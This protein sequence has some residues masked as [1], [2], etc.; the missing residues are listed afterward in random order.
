MSCDGRMA[1]RREA[2]RSR[3]SSRSSNDIA[4]SRPYVTAHIGSVSA[5]PPSPSCS[6]HLERTPDT[7]SGRLGRM[8][9]AEARAGNC[10]R[11]L[12]SMMINYQP[13]T[14]LSGDV[15]PDPLQED[16]HSKVRLRQELEMN[17]CPHEAREK[18][19]D[20]NL[21][22]LQDGEA[23]PDHCHAALVEVAKRTRRRSAPETLA[24]QPSR[25]AAFLD[26]DLRHTGQ[27]FS[28]LLERRGIADDEDLG[29]P[30]DRE[31]LLDAYPSG[32]IRLYA[33]PL[34][35]GRWSHPGGPDDRLARDALTRHD[36]AVGVDPIDALSEPHL[37]TQPLQTRR[38]FRGETL[39]ETAQNPLPHVDQN[40]SRRRRSGPPK[41][42]A[43]RA[44]HQ[45]ADRGGKLHTGGAGPH[46]HERQEVPVAA[47]VFLGL[48]L[49]EGAQDPVPNRDRIREALQPRRESREF[50]VPE[51]VMPD[52]GRQDENIVRKRHSLPIRRI[53]EDASP[54]LVHAR[55]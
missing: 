19:A 27:G 23:L 43:Q 6:P 17:A 5:S 49:L 54:I 26:R 32:P 47:R 28:V 16:A 4:A 24:D 46:Q 36:D 7:R 44:A 34:P 22:G 39:R 50:V 52:S 10:I 21:A 42:R 45:R 18:S 1:G 31:V 13:G 55:A 20:A 3:S 53:D 30:W 37:H 48:G 12:C 38:R 14:A 35:G 51:V 8:S 2:G 9:G 25:I 29:M 15:G 33:K 11:G 40:D 41:F